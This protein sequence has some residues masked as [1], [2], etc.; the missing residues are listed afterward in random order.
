MYKETLTVFKEDFLEPKE[1]N[2]ASVTG[3]SYLIVDGAMGAITA[4]VLAESDVTLASAITVNIKTSDAKDGSFET[5]A[6]G[7]VKAGS[8]ETGEVMGTIAIPFDVKKYTKAEIDSATTNSGTVRVTG[9][10]LPR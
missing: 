4:N 9:G 8:Y 7:T 3:D 5:V 6:S 1:I 2:V 10:Y